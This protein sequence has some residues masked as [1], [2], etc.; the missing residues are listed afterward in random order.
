[1]KE[2]Q[3]RI[4][5][6]VFNIQGYSIHDGP[7]IRTTVFVKGCPLRCLWCQNP[8]SNASRPELMSYGNKCTGCGRCVEVCPQHAVQIVVSDGKAAAKT[9][10]GR[11]TACGQCVKACPS[12]AR[13]IAGR[14]MT[15]EE[16]FKRVAEDKIFYY[17]SGGGMTISGGEPLMYPEFTAAL[18]G[19]CREAGIHTAIESSCFASEA[20]ADLVFAHV[21]LALLDIKH[22]DPAI[23]KRLTGVSNEEILAR[24]RHIRRDLKV[25]MIIRVPVIPTC[26]DSRENIEATA[27]FVAKE[28]GRDVPIHLLPYHS[29]G[30]AKNESLG[31]ASVLKIK[32]PTADAMEG[33]KELAEGY[34]LSVQ[35][36]GSV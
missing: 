9:S 4:A 11:C 34:G 27:R 21:D 22:M 15:A 23:H 31:K 12:G 18:L 36:G 10:R 6:P 14:E 35:I 29:L 24:I 32:P 25:P 33:L 19:A 20:A 2:E 8:E 3:L 13:E 28:L 7:G 17:S 26:N 5:A 16:V 1:M 30:E